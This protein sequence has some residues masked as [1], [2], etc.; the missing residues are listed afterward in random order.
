MVAGRGRGQ[1]DGGAVFHRIWAAY[2]DSEEGRAGF[3]LAVELARRSRAR[4][5]VV[6]IVPPAEEDES[7]ELHGAAAA[8]LLGLDACSRWR[9]RIASAAACAAP[10]LAVEACV[11]CGHPPVALRELLECGRPDLVVAGT[12]RIGGPWRGLLG[13]VSQRLRHRSPCPVMLVRPG[14]CTPRRDI[15]LVGVDDLER[16]TA[17]LDLGARLGRTLCA[18]VHLVH[19]FAE[20]RSGMRM[21]SDERDLLAWASE[22]LDGHAPAVAAELREGLAGPGLLAACTAHRP[23]VAVVGVRPHAAVRSLVGHSVT[24]RLV[25]G[26][27]CPVAVARPG[28]EGCW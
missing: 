10:E 14:R 8:E 26:A 16:A 19:V 3:E 23:Q 25:N 20:R 1:A 13:G 21:P 22:R 15:V 7:V 11:I 6:H 24:D 9:A 5:T 4:L 18:R 12:K 17:A 2:D 27:P 28:G